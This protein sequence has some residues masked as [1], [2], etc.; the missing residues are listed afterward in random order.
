MVTH[1]VDDLENLIRQ[2]V[3][4]ELG[5]DPSG[6]IESLTFR[7][8]LTLY[9]TWRSRLISPAPRSSHL[10]SEL[11]ASAEYSTHRS[12]VDAIVEKSRLGR[13]LKPHQ[14]RRINTIHLPTAARPSKRRDRRDLDLL[15]SEWGIQ[16][17]HLST[18]LDR[19]GLV[20][21]TRELLF[22]VFR[23]QDAFFIGIYGHEWTNEEFVRICV[24]NWPSAQ[25]FHEAT[26]STSLAN[27]I[28]S[29][30]REPL[31][32]A[33]V[34]TFLQ[35]DGHVYMPPGQTLSGSPLSSARK[36]MQIVASLTDFRNSLTAA[37]ER[38]VEQLAATGVT[39]EAEQNWVAAKRGRR[40]GFV[41]TVS[42]GFL[43]V[44]TLLD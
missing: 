36:S 12:V 16:H 27:P 31:R 41:D 28:R 4:T 39:V 5:P 15:V 11:L 3:L 33:G 18:T 20:V 25:L 10:S 14:S 2:D 17:L 13:D 8:I 30:D 7:E 42:R 24:R 32:N 22:A 38:I 44:V 35:V 1:V 34:T 19:N 43:P 21:G 40:Y 9:G 37:P 23:P 29:G 6:E 26:F